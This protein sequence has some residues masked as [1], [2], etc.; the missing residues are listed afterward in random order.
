MYATEH[1]DSASLH[2]AFGYRAALSVSRFPLNLLPFW[3]VAA[4][5]AWPPTALAQAASAPMIGSLAPA[6]APTA[7]TDASGNTWRVT[8]GIVTE[9]AMPVGVTSG[10][11]LLVDAGGVFWQQNRECRWWPWRGTRWEGPG[12][13]S[14]PAGVAVP[15]CTPAPV[16]TILQAPVTAPADGGSAQVFNY[17]DGFA[18]AVSSGAIHLTRGAVQSGAAINPAFAPGGHAAGAF[19]YASQISIAHGFQTSFKFR[20]SPITGSVTDPSITAFAFVIQNSRA[21]QYPNNGIASWGGAIFGVDAA[22]DAN[23]AGF[24]DYDLPGQT[25]IYSSVAIKFDA[26]PAN[27]KW[28]TQAF[29]AKAT[30]IGATGLYLNGGPRGALM[31]GLD[32]TAAGINLYSGDVFAATVTYDTRSLTLVLRDSLTGAQYRTSWPVDIP[33]VIGGTNAW[34]GFSGGIGPNVSSEQLITAWTV[35]I[36]SPPPLATPTLAPAAGSYPAPQT[37]FIGCPAA[38]TCYYTINGTAPGSASRRYAGPFQVAANTVVQAIA[39]ASQHADSAVAVTHYEIQGEQLPTINL[40]DGFADAQGLIVRNGS[41][42]LSGTTLQLTDDAQLNEA[43]SAWFPVPLGIATFH[44]SFTLRFRWTGGRLA[45]GA[46]FCLQNLPTTTPTGD[47]QWLSG[48]PNVVANAAGGLGFS[49]PTNAVG[50]QLSGLQRSAC[51][52]FDTFTYGGNVTGLYLGYTDP[53][54]TG[55]RIRGVDLLKGHPVRASLTYDGQLLVLTLL[56]TKTRG[57]F[58]HS[59]PV[60]LPA[61]VGGTTAYVGFTASTGQFTSVQTVESWTFGP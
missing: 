60:N 28:V 40:P 39:I 2:R 18:A 46:A 27:G 29:P 35:A 53:R 13:A 58:T 9:N 48:G 49:G 8:A 6:G 14:G 31:P 19:W 1:I 51:I 34:L 22:S 5:A 17:P 56:D 26:D 10:V 44:T 55:V 43:G 52:K 42:V 37:V 59:W 11:V 30:A 3:L 25:P 45:Y 54:P 21:S 15:A 20:I 47:H 12:A 4:S 23:M 7:I 32:M 33:A 41:A 61:A 24:G 57:V 50:G 36:G 38:A 16:A